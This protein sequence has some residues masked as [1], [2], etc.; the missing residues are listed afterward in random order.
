MVQWL[1]DF[2]FLRAGE[3]QILDILGCPVACPYSICTTLNNFN[4]FLTKIMT[5]AYAPQKIL[6]WYSQR[7]ITRGECDEML[8]ELFREGYRSGLEMII[9]FSEN[10]TKYMSF[11][12]YLLPPYQDYTN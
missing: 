12:K 3:R 9:R 8:E 10:M 5:L 7:L 4:F 6:R 1:W 2:T 11:G